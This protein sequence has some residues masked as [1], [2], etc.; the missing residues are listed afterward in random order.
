M[1]PAA[2]V[3]TG[4]VLLALLFHVVAFHGQHLARLRWDRY[5]RRAAVRSAKLRQAIQ[6]MDYYR[7]QEL[8]AAQAAREQRSAAKHEALGDWSQEFNNLL[9][10]SSRTKGAR[11]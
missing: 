9:F 10:L 4:L 7:R 2:V 5:Y 6:A 3:G 8:A 11:R 1:S